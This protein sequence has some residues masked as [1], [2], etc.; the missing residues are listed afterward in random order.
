MFHRSPR[1]LSSDSKSA[2][3]IHLF[4]IFIIAHSEF[5]CPSILKCL[6]SL[7]SNV[8]FL[9]LLTLTRPHTRLVQLPSY[10]SPK[11]AVWAS[12]ATAQVIVG[13]GPRARVSQSE[14]HRPLARHLGCLPRR[15]FGGGCLEC[16]QCGMTLTCR[17]RFPQ[18]HRH[19][20]RRQRCC[21]CR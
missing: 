15:V 4:V 8:I 14:F 13:A 10:S 5:L 7:I 1:I 16:A 12:S 20:F 19:F 21:F 11:V 18:L 9:L 17:S 3:K 6:L 2:H